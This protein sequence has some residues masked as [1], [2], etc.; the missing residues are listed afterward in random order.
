MLQRIY[1]TAWESRKAL[2][3]HLEQLEE[4]RKR[5]HRK[6]ARELDLSRFPEELGSGLPSGTP[7]ARSCARRWRTTSGRR[8]AAAAT[9]RSTPRT[10]ARALLWETS[11]HLDF[12]AEGMYP[13]MDFDTDEQGARLLRQA[14]ELPVPHP[15]LPLQ[16]AQL[17]RAAAA[18]G[19]ARDGLPLRAIRR[20]PRPAARPRLHPGRQP[21]L[22]H[23]RAAGGGGAR[24]APSSR[25]TS[26]RLRVRRGS[27]PSRAVD[28]PEKAESVGTDEGWA[29]A[30]DALQRRSTSWAWTTSSTRA[31]ARST[32]RRST[33]RSPTR[34]AARGSSRRCRSTSTSPSASI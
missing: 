16:D 17:P 31:R 3:A 2:A 29:H 27:Q 6:L 14:D 32:G 30:D 20:D 15:D 23:R 25:S 22:L 21:H 12:Y 28:P 1:G 19:R 13:P 4:A 24:R 8:C 9:S 10:S 26:T 33:C 18:A 11:G 7:R 5:D 34:S